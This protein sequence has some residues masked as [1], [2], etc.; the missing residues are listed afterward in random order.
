M[1]TAENL[2]FLSLQ[3]FSSGVA[4]YITNKYAVNMIF[5][6]Y[7]PLKIGG[8]VKKNKEKFI[9]EISDLVERDII[10]SS[11]IKDNVLK[12]NFKKTMEETSKDFFSKSLYEVFHDIKIEELIGIEETINNTE[13]LIR[14]NLG[15]VLSKLLINIG[16]HLKIEDML[17]DEQI[18][19]IIDY[20]YKEINNVINENGEIKN[21]VSN[22]YNEQ[23][24][25]SLSQVVSKETCS[26]ITRIISCEIMNSI[27]E[28]LD[29]KKETK[30]L[31]DKVL[32]LIDIKAVMKDLQK[33]F[34]SKTIEE[35]LSEE[36]IDKLSLIIYKNLDELIKSEDG[37]T[38]INELINEGIISARN[39]EL[40]VFEM[41]PIHFGRTSSEYLVKIIRNMA[42]YFISWIEENK[43]KIETM[44]DDS[45]LE[46]IDNIDDELRKSMISKVKDS[47]LVD[48]SSKNQIVD[49]I[50]DFITTYADNEEISS[51]LYDKLIKFLEET[52]I[53]DIVKILEENNLLNNEKITEKFLNKW[54]Y[55]GKEVSKDLLKKQSSKTINNLINQ[56][57]YRLFNKN[58]KPNLYELLNSNKDKIMSYLDDA[59]FNLVHS[60]IDNI[61]DAKMSDLIKEDKVS[62]FSKMLPYKIDKY[63]KVKSSRY[64]RNISNMI[65]N[66]IKDIRLDCIIKEHENEIIDSSLEKIIEFGKDSIEKYKSY[67]VK[68]II[69]T[70]NSN[71]VFV[72]DI[73]EKVYDEVVNNLPT[74]V[75]GN[76]KK[77]IYDNLI[78][79]DEEEL[80]DIAQSFMGKQLKPLSMFGAFLGSVVGLIFGVTLQNINGTYGFYNNVQSTLIACLILGGV[81]VMTNVIALWM[82][83]CPYEK[84]TFVSKI[85]IFKRFAI[86]YIP[87][88]KNSF[89]S[90]M[91]YFIDNELLSGTRLSN[92]FE[93]KK[94]D[95][96]TSVFNNISNSNDKTLLSIVKAR[97]ESLSKS[98]YKAV[99]KVCRKNSSTIS[100]FVANN[101]VQIEG[102][103]LV[104]NSFVKTKILS[105]INNLNKHEDKLITYLEEKLKINKSISDILPEDMVNIIND[106]INNDINSLINKSIE[107]EYIEKL[108]KDLIINNAQIYN[109]FV[110]KDL[111]EVISEKIFINLDKSLKN[112][113]SI[114]LLLLQL[115]AIL[116]NIM[117]NYIEI[118]L[119]EEKRFDELYNG[120]IK[121]KIDND[122]YSLTEKSIDIISRYANKN[123]YVISS[124]VIKIVRSNLNFFVKMAYDFADGDRL[125]RDVI[126]NILTNKLETLLV[127]EKN[128]ISAIL[129]N[130]LYR[131]IYPS[132][133]KDLGITTKEIN[134]NLLLD[135]FI[136][137]LKQ[138]DD[139]KNHIHDASDLVIN[140]VKDIEVKEITDCL[141]IDTI[142]LA[143]NKCEGFIN[144]LEKNIIENLKV[145]INEANEFIYE[146]ISNKLMSKLY[147]ISLVEISWEINREDLSYTVKNIVEIIKTSEVIRDCTLNLCDNIYNSSIKNMKLD[148]V[149]NQDI[150]IKDINNSI[151]IVL[152][153]KDF[154]EKNK[155]LSNDIIELVINNKFRFISED[156]RKGLIE[157]TIEGGLNTI[158]RYITPLLISL[159]LKDI[160][161]KE[162]EHMHAKEIHMLFK[163]FSGDFFK[164]LYV[165]GGFGFIFGINLYLSIIL[166]IIDN[167][168]TKKI[169]GRVVNSQENLFKE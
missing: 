58:I 22:L 52:K 28:L 62:Y 26:K 38:K 50:S 118:E 49:K 104:V 25:I 72:N 131:E 56:D 16:E 94:G 44:I 140:K 54:E 36:G 21:L 137:G 158:E 43:E 31:V 89:A 11:T 116:S 18:S 128:E 99:L 106:K 91:A 17:S 134:T 121:D 90:G 45:I 29:S 165:Y 153:N 135:R 111:K 12:E 93:S 15:S 129:Y 107:E 96:K 101:S 166:L 32:S 127:E 157:K 149:L 167:V 113:K 159:D 68:E 88:N 77:V 126:E 83:F 136:Y 100:G 141:N 95:L 8:A 86:G 146:L 82:I 114:N 147:T 41:F 4:G 13:E 112:N 5:K 124:L 145:N 120:K 66:Y 130:C 73:T 80:C 110:N 20:I 69:K 98:L 23:G 78:K 7:T 132:K 154:N 150:L 105:Y 81:G 152:E 85:P 133:I 119:N 3:V 55:C 161:L 75:D 142:E 61:L 144:I 64:K 14:E 48:F 103:K 71:E 123:Q 19:T 10:N 164:K 59:I 125:V 2:F 109:S 30:Q 156:L 84:N 148:K 53:K 42:P 169:E 74:I 63:L 37:K 60:K 39:I 168:Y 46:S 34:G 70:I 143:Y 155:V 79:L 102:D 76:V 40:T 65:N 33:S 47:M 151:N 139:F 1:I 27:D 122:L 24:N 57:F 35:V 115:K 108:I 160:T 97:K 67:E 162:V 6:E 92:L 9:D 51:K 117:I 138:S 87:A 163:S